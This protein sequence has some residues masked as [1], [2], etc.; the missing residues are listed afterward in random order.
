MLNRI[1]KSGLPHHVPDLTGKA[2]SLMF[3]TSHFPSPLPLT[4]IAVLSMN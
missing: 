1:L 2:L 4:F 3:I